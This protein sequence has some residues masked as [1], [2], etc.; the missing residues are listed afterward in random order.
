MSENERGII[1]DQDWNVVGD[2]AVMDDP[3]TDCLL[4]L[5]RI[6]NLDVSRRV[7]RAG[8]PLVDNRLT[9]ELFGRAAER[10]GLASRVVRRSLADMTELEL[11]AVLLLHDKQACL[12]I[13]VDQQE[14]SATVLIP[15]TGMGER[16]VS[17]DT[18]AGFYSGYALFARPRFNPGKGDNESVFRRKSWFWG[19]I[20]SSWR[21]YRDVFV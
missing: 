14:K 13:A 10:I 8:L 1:S 5:A 2:E 15:E 17:F 20:F 16:S 9:V 3:L 21:V 6:H 4:Q 18:L 19:A 7:L 11:P 12:L